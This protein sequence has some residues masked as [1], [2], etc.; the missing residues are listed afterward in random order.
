MMGTPP[1][2]QASPHKKIRLLFTNPK[3]IKVGLN[4]FMKKLKRLL[5]EKVLCG[6]S[7]TTY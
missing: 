4:R 2:L 3:A 7:A 5:Y 1:C 6:E